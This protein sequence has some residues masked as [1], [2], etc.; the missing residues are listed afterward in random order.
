MFR[1]EHHAFACCVL[2]Q[3]ESI[4][5]SNVFR[6]HCVRSKRNGYEETTPSF[7]PPV[8]GFSAPPSPPY[9]MGRFSNDAIWVDVLSD[10]LG[11]ERPRAS[12]AGGTN[13]AY[14]GCN[15]RVGRI[16]SFATSGC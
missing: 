8:F 16:T 2:L 9:Y 12:L 4:V 11:L 1:M 13:Y 5:R 14:G 15:Y 7:R 6:A 3:L 10:E